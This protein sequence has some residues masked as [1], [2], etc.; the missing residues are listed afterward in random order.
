V[1]LAVGLAGVGVGILGPG[2]TWLTAPGGAGDLADR[3]L[4]LDR[5][6]RV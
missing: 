2:H 6:A 3:A 5:D 4:G 1:D